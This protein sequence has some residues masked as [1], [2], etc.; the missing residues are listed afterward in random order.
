MLEDII[1]TFVKIELKNIQ[2]LLTYDYPESPK[3]G[4]E[5][6][7]REAVVDITLDFLRKMKHDELA[8]L[9]KSSKIY[10]RI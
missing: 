8:D 6:S 4:E 3:R 2:K 10:V 7:S 1:I 9:L 5:R